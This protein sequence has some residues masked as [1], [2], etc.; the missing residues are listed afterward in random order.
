L[1]R[2]CTRAIRRLT[3]CRLISTNDCGPR[4]EHSF[5]L[6]QRRARSAAG[7]MLTTFWSQWRAVYVGPRRWTG[8]RG[9]HGLPPHRRATLW[10]E[11]IVGYAFLSCYGIVE[12]PVTGIADD[13]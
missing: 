8:S 4:L 3:A 12:R 9:S 5:K 1:P 11:P 6:P 7:L 2:C 13:F 10:P